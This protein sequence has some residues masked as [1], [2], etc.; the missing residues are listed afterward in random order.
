[1]SGYQR[2]EWDWG[3]RGP[4]CLVLCAVSTA[5]TLGLGD[6]LPLPSSPVGRFS[7]GCVTL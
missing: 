2:C 3:P 6:R 5:V 4:R 1:M 7:L